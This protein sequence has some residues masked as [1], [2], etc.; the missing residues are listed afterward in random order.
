MVAWWIKNQKMSMIFDCYALT[1]PFS[2][3]Y[4]Q[5]KLIGIYTGH[6]NLLFQ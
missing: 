1:S 5:R 3:E 4:S 6:R 2:M